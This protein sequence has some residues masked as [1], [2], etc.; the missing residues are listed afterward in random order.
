MS[1]AQDLEQVIKIRNFFIYLSCIVLFILTKRYVMRK[2][3]FLVNEVIRKIRVRI[4]DKIRKSDLY[5]LEETGTSEVYASIASDSREI[6]SSF[7]YAGDAFP[8][9]LMVVFAAIYMAFIS[10]PSF[11]IIVCSLILG[12]ISYARSR[13]ASKLLFQEAAKRET[14]MFNVLDSILYG[15]KEIKVNT[16]KSNSLFNHY[17]EVAKK[18][19]DAK[20]FAIFKTIMSY[21]ATQ[22]F[23]FVLLAG[24]IFILPEYTSMGNRDLVRVTAAVLFMIGPITTVAS[25]WPKVVDANVRSENIME[26]ERKIESI[27]ESNVSEFNSSIPP[28]SVESEIKFSN[29]TFQY[30]ENKEVEM[31]DPFILGPIDLTLPKGKVIFVTGG[32]GAGKSTFLK[33]LSGLYHPKTGSITLD[34]KPLLRTQYQYYREMYAIIFTDFFLF[35]RL[36]GLDEEQQQNI[37]ELLKEMMIYKKTEVLDGR[38]LNLALSTGQRKRLAL[39]IAI[40][41]DKPYYIF[42][43]V[44]ADQD[45]QFR[46]YFYEKVLGRLKEMGKTVI[47]VSHDQAYFHVADMRYHLSNGKC[48]LVTD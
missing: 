24:I 38:F 2:S 19:M 20:V 12:G 8:G 44:A 23:F 25:V 16:K 18:Q 17:K 1:T 26:L 7:S 6:A 41:E 30:P 4:A 47:V 21:V 45:P 35:E 13:A 31:L 27:A 10:F 42:D 36:Y 37:E 22:S 34:E 29:V 48:E 3:T 33:L 5:L 43:E 15:F 14:E 39:A 11:L 40:L 32:N 9:L 28:L 46:Q